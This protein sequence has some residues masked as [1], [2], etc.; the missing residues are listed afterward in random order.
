MRIPYQPG[1]L[2]VWLRHTDDSLEAFTLYPA[3][4]RSM[5]DQGRNS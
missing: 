3:L 2:V 4:T 1:A 5:L